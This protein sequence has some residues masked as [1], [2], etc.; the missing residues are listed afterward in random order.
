ALKWL[1]GEQE[2]VVIG[3]DS[4]ATY[5]PITYEVKKIY[6][7]YLTHDGEEVDLAVAGGAGDSSL[8]KY[9]YT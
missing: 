4:R 3:S 5:G 6:P 1:I 2:A 7:I 9:G 8:A